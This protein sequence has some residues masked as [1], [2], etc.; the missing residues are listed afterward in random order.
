MDA[1]PGRLANRDIRD[2][3]IFDAFYRNTLL[4][5]LVA[6]WDSWRKR[7]MRSL[8]VGASALLAAE[9]VATLL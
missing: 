8:V 4:I 9:F 3:C 5:V 7:L 6:G 1:A 2:P